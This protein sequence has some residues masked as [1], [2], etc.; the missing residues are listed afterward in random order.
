MGQTIEEINEKIARKEAVVVTAE[1]IIDLARKKG[2]KKAAAEVDVVT[3]G[4]FAPMCSSGAYFNLGHTR[5][6]IKLG[7]GRVT[8]NGVPAYT[9]LAAVDVFLGATAVPDEDPRNTIHPGRFAY[10]GGHVIEELVG[11]KDIRLSA[12]AYTT[13]CYP[14]QKLDTW[15]RLVD[16]NEAVLFN[17]RNCYQNYNVAVNLSDRVIYTYMGILQPKMR[18][19]TF[20]SAGQLSPL[21]NDPLYRT[22]G[23][24]TRIF[25]GGGI[26]HIVGP[27]TQHNPD[28]PRSE[29]GVPRCGAG[30]LSVTGSLKQMSANWIRGASFTGYGTTMAI[31]IGVPIPIL[32]EQILLNTCVTDSEIHAQVVDY[33]SS[34]PE[35]VPGSIGEVTYAELKSGAITV[36]GRKVPTSG[37][38]SYVRAKEIAHILKSWIEEGRFFLTQ[39]VETVPSVDSGVRFKPLSERPIEPPAGVPQKS[40]GLP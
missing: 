16:M 1:E 12:T 8:F 6:R 32:D 7:G 3:T 15:I 33:S 26:G 21:L 18:N 5:P 27:G 9:G 39:P 14:R 2:A 4:T 17:I 35:N 28:V 22:I 25:L 34:Y 23:M 19:A 30:T 29:N 24:G 40:G 36:N 37:L 20:C 38:S 31:G 13:D 10:G 11:G